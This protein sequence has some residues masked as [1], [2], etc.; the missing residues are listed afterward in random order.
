MFAQLLLTLIVISVIGILLWKAFGKPLIERYSQPDE[1]DEEALKQRLE[2]LNRQ[3]Q[4]LD[5][6]EEEIELQKRQEQLDE[7]IRFRQT[8]LHAEQDFLRDQQQQKEEGE[9]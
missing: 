1:T 8:Q 3:K 9:K 4:M 6:M 7:E 2:D 5:I